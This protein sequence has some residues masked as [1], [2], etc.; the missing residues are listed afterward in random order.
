M[1]VFFL[2]F[3]K[4]LLVAIL[5]LYACIIRIPKIGSLP[6]IPNLDKLIHFLFYFVFSIV[7]FID[8]TKN[9]TNFSFL[10]TVLIIVFI[11]TLHGGIIEIFQEKFFPPRNGNFTD[12]FA[13]FIGVIAGL[14]VIY[15]FRKYKSVLK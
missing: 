8:F 5:I 12:L 7:F 9:K 6:E 3:W 10:K 2:R 1:R 11:T 4:T 15:F 13:D 14:V